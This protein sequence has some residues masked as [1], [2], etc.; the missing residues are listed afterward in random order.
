[1]LSQQDLHLTENTPFR[2]QR[3]NGLEEGEILMFPEVDR[4]AIS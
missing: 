2:V 3:F 1:M 4:T